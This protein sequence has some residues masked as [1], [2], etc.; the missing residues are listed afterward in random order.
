M[1][2]SKGILLFARNNSQIDYIKQAYFLAQ[3][4]K[5]YLNLPT[6]IVTDSVAYLSHEYPDHAKVFDKVIPI[7]WDQDDARENTVFSQ[8]EKHSLKSFYDGTLISKKLDWKNELRSHAY[9]VS[10]YTATLLLDTDIVI[11]NS[12]WLKCFEHANDFLIY[13]QSTDLLDVDRGETFERISDTS[14]DFYWATAV[15]FRKTETNKTFFDLVQ[16]IQENWEHYCSIF[17][18]NTPY[19]RNDYA[20]SIA[21]HIMNG[22]QKGDF[23]KSMPGKLYFVTD[24]CILWD[25]NKEKNKIL[26]EKPRHTGEYTAITIKDANLHCMNKFSLNRCIDEQ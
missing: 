21:I 17:Q 1:T 7:V 10:P 12:D 26:L 9:D 13:K 8:F 2:A 24:K 19:F 20:F 11:C 5:K 22:Y 4:A 25:I 18:I 3:R 23:A 16:H 14:I 15:F 6:S